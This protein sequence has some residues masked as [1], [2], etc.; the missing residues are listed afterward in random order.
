MN[1]ISMS[2]KKAIIMS[3]KGLVKRWI[4]W[5]VN[6][7]IIIIRRRIMNCSRT[8]NSWWSNIRGS[9]KRWKGL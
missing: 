9:W 7:M 3:W 6:K 5:P 4:Y 2:S 1:G 8:M